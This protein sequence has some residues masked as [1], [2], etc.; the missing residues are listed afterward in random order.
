MH[1]RF[2]DSLPAALRLVCPLLLAAF[3]LVPSSALAQKL[4]LD[5]LV[6]DNHAGAVTVRFGIHVD[7]ISKIED[8]LKS[9]SEM[10]LRVKAMLSRRRTGWL[11]ADLAE[12][13]LVGALGYDPLTRE[14]HVIRPGLGKLLKGGE[15]GPLMSRVWGDVSLELIPWES[16]E[17][18]KEYVLDFEMRLARTDVPGWIRTTLFFVSWDVVGVTTYRLDFTY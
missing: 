18:G 2:P 8:E 5:K 9:G 4:I 14:F 12:K 16:L 15:L 6:L 11:A 1:A 10:E 7:D 17:R 13:E 3:L